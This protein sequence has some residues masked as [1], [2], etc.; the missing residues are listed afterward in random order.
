[1][2]LFGEGVTRNFL[3]LLEAETLKA[4][5][6]LVRIVLGGLLVFA[7]AWAALQA[8]PG[9]AYLA[10][11]ALFLGSLALGVAYTKV[12]TLDAYEVSLRDNWNRWMRWSVTSRTVGECYARVHDQSVARRRGLAVA[13]LVP[14]GLAHIVIGVLALNGPPSL[15]VLVTLFGIDATFLG[16][17]AGRRL[18]QRLWYRRFVRSCNELLREGQLGLWGVF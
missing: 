2:H 15:P 6:S 7:L 18:V 12:F 3:T 11:P 4:R 16:F 13:L 8:R 5:R 14:L 10:A 1:M 9:Y 17:A